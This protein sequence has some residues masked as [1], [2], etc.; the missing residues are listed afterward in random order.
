MDIINSIEK[1]GNFVLKRLIEFIGIL[2]LVLSAFIL[3]ALISYSPNDPNFIYPSSQIIEN[4]LG[5]K[6][7]ITADFLFQSIG[8]IAF[9][10]P[11]T[12]IFL[13]KKKLI[14]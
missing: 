3:V 10:L 13:L 4:L 11:I 8:L 2:I 6:G 7:S 1:A 12:L 5:I 9:F 14:K